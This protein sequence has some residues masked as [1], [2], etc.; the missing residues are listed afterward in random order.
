[1]QVLSLQAIFLF[2]GIFLFSILLLMA[3][4]FRRHADE[5]A[6]LW[7]SATLL[8]ALATS[9]TAWRADLPPW[10][11]FLLPN[12]LEFA[13]PLLAAL[14]LRALMGPVPRLAR[15]L[16]LTVGAVVVLAAGLFWLAEHHRQ[17][18]VPYISAVNALL[19]L[20]PL[21]LIRRGKLPQA[22]MPLVRILMRVLVFKSFIW[23]AR[24]PVFFLGQ[25]AHAMDP[26][27]TN[28]LIF[29]SLLLVGILVQIAYIGVRFSN[30]YDNRLALERMR[31]RLQN[32]LA[33][34][35]ALLRQQHAPSGNLALQIAHEINQ[36][37]G[38]IR[39]S[40]ETA[41]IKPFHEIQ[42]G[43]LDDLLKDIDRISASLASASALAAQPAPD[44]H[45]LQTPELMFKM[46]S[47]AQL[48]GLSIVVRDSP[49]I[50]QVRCDADQL[51]ESWVA[52]LKKLCSESAT[53]IS[54]HLV[55]IGNERVQLNV[56]TRSARQ[57]CSHAALQ[58]GRMPDGMSARDAD[59]FLDLLRLEH[60]VRD[61]AGRMSMHLNGEN[62]PQLTMELVL[63]ARI[64]PSQV[65]HSEV[66]P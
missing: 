64:D 48:A 19:M 41:A 52:A 58:L 51:A 1:M 35:D 13:H 3:W 28:W 8:S 29:V 43:E 17:A 42:A 24:I 47:A 63:P 37:L 57:L 11:G 31:M 2:Y 20:W 9:V 65:L 16:A 10:L 30:A 62:S 4:L 53:T 50:L 46:V 56:L 12:T 45:W 61:H 25:G 15:L 60:V 23:L 59:I 27:W 14:A 66:A 26:Q 7:M 22:E 49:T 5:S 36:P 39:L 38:A 33:E 32:T 6:R 40:L 54:L 18:L 21:W 44:L 55:P 34:R